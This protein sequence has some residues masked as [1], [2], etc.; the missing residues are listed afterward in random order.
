METYPSSVGGRKKQQVLLHELLH[1]ATIFICILRELFNF[2]EKFAHGFH[3][4]VELVDF[5]KELAGYC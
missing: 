1:Q 4:R 3:M 2:F 5:V